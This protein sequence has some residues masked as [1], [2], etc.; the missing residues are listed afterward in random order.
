M[1]ASPAVANGLVFV[2]NLGP[3][4]RVW[5]FDTATGT[6]EWSSVID[7]YAAGRGSP[8]VVG[9]LVIVG[10]SGGDE[11]SGTPPHRGSLQAFT[12]ATRSLVTWPDTGAPGRPH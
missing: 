5:A 3:D 1:T 7:Q 4:A 6:L 11:E 2:T 12:A 9:P 10:Q 8:V